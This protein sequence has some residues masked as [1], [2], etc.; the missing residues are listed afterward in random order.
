MI[1]GA[2]LSDFLHLIYYFAKPNQKI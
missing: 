1:S 2:S